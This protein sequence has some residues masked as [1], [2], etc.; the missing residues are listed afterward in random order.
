MKI[1]ELKVSLIFLA[2]GMVGLYVLSSHSSLKSSKSVKLIPPPSYFKDFNFGFA[3][4]LGASLWIRYLQDSDYCEVDSERSYNPK[5]DLAEILSTN[6]P[7][8]RCHL[9]WS[10]QIIDLITELAPKFS[11]P[12]KFGALN[13]N[14]VVDDREGA[15]RIYEKGMGRFPSDF[16]LYMGAAYLY[17]FEIQDPKRAAE[18]L[19]KA[20]LHGGSPYLARLAARVYSKAGKR[21]LGISVLEDYLENNP[22]GENADKAR[23][24]LE[25]LRAEK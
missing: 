20:Y 21:E 23:E 5:K 4:L 2:A 13:L 17:L 15:R 25:E 24:R 22:S 9:G 7:E 6:V 8:S 12:H 16:S 10:Y 14:V 3:D 11:Y 19:H 18:L 1:F